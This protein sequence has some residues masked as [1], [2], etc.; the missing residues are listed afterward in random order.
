MSYKIGSFNMHNLGFNVAFSKN[1]RNLSKIAQIIR[2]EKFD[3]IALQEVLNEGK[4]FTYQ[5]PEGFKK[6]I[7]H[8]LGDTYDF[9]WADSHSEENNNRSEGY[10]FLWNKRRLGLVKT[11]TDNGTRLSEP[12]MLSKTNGI[13]RAPFYGRFSPQGLPGGCN[14]E[15]RLI[16]VHNYYG[17]NSYKEAFDKRRAELDTLLKIVYPKWSTKIYKNN[18]PHYTILLGDY[19]LELIRPNRSMRAAIYTQAD[20]ILISEKYNNMKIKTVQDELTSLKA[21]KTDNQTFYVSN[22]DHFSFNPDEMEGIS[23]T[24]KRIDCVNKYYDGDNE[25]YFYEISDHIPVMMEIELR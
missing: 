14:C 2:N 8:E 12:E 7:L 3:I 9:V 22:Y 1:G 23:K 21:D 18:L 13:I 25:K 24:W 17:N 10:A 11:E 6:S 20:D 4:A 5:T 15:I 19:N 16:C